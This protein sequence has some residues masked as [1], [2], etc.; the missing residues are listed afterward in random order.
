MTSYDPPFDQAFDQAF[1]AVIGHEGGYTSDARDPGN[2]TG[3]AVGQGACKG[4]QW[5]IS[6]A[7]YPALDIAGLTPAAARAR[8]DAEEMRAILPVKVS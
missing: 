1:A 6:A 3:G 2:W 5:G 7:A 8:G 4:T